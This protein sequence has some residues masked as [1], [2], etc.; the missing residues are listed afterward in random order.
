ML[1]KIIIPTI[2][3]TAIGAMYLFF[4]I[5][6]IDN[7]PV[8]APVDMSNVSVLSTE[9]STSTI[10]RTFEYNGTEST[11]SINFDGYNACRK[12]TWGTSTQ[13]FCKEMLKD[14]IDANIQWAKESIDA[15]I[16]KVQIVDYSDEVALKDL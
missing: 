7:F 13:A 3:G 2:A 15:Q 4:G 16:K 11:T 10:S 1:K 14:Q 12:G 9:I 8:G 5:S 6:N